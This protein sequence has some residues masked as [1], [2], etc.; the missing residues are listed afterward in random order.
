[1]ILGGTIMVSLIMINMYWPSPTDTHTGEPPVVEH[2][3]PH[4]DSL[5]KDHTTLRGVQQKHSLTAAACWPPA[6]HLCP[7][8][9]LSPGQTVSPHHGC[10]QRAGYS[11]HLAL[12]PI[13]PSGHSQYCNNNKKY[14]GVSKSIFP[15]RPSLKVKYIKLF[16][17]NYKGGQLLLLLLQLFRSLERSL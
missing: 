13:C 11:S 14:P 5:S 1:M 15:H 3:Y 12:L 16:K 10:I 9:T 17:T 2:R 8:H 6:L 4:S 7:C